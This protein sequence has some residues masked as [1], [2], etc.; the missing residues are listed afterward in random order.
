LGVPRGLRRFIGVSLHRAL[1]LR[2]LMLPRGTNVDVTARNHLHFFTLAPHITRGLK[3][4]SKLRDLTLHGVLGAGLLRGM[5]RALVDGRASQVTL[6]SAVDVRPVMTPRA[7]QQLSMFVSAVLTTHET[8]LHHDLFALARRCKDALVHG[9][10]V[11]EPSVAL[12][13]VGITRVL[14]DRVRRWLATPSVVLSNVG[15]VGAAPAT[16][17]LRFQ[18]PFYAAPT[19]RNTQAALVVAVAAHDDVLRFVLSVDP[20]SV[21]EHKAVQVMHAALDELT[22]VVAHDAR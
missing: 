20:R 15:A 12:R 2:P 22:A 16:T 4:A 14:P 17:T 10:R 3:H 7:S 5:V 21:D 6:C 11:E 8:A 19:V 9:L 13:V 18:N 1:W